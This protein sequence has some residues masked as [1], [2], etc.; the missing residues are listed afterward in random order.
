MVSSVFAS[1]Y[2]HLKKKCNRSGGTWIFDEYSPVDYGHCECPTNMELI[3]DEC[4][5]I[6]VPE[7]PQG[8]SSGP[9]WYS[10]CNMDMR[11]T[12]RIRMQRFRDYELEL[13]D[14]EYTMRYI[15]KNFFGKGILIIRNDKGKWVYLNFVEVGE[16]FFRARQE[17]G[18]KVSA[19]N[20]KAN[21]LKLTL[22]EV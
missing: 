8:G 2:T 9:R 7:E 11:N 12:C 3:D 16:L 5:E 10:E 19:F 13:D 15:G 18:L 22:K 20:T 14:K 6:S 4:V 21:M 17:T 1:D